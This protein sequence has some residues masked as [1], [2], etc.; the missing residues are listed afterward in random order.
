MERA[1]GSER[2]HRQDGD[3][4]AQPCVDPEANAI[5][6]TALSEEHKKYS[7]KKQRDEGGQ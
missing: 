7:D 3:G 5:V 4:A 2:Q 6:F 1:R